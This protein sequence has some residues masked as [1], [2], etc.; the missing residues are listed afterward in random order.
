[1][2]IR[3]KAVFEAGRGEIVE[4][5]SRFIAHVQAVD[6]VE[7]A[8]EFIEAVKKKYWDAR[9]NCSAFSVGEMNP[10]TRCSDD[11]EPGGTAGK[12]ILEVIQGS[13]IRNIVI[14]VTRYF[15]GTLLGTGGLVRAYTEAAKAG[16]ENA[17]IIEKIPATRMKLF[18][19]YTDL[20]KIQYILAQNQVTVENTEYTDK[21]EIRAL[22][23]EKEKKALCRALT[24]G[25]G[26]RVHIEDGEDVYY[27]TAE[28]E[29]IIF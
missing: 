17:V 6:S 5:K 21:V 7:E 18:T 1:M 14:V 4:K 28:G 3:H 11:G 8:Q 9:H 13:G 29:V 15:G 2:M 10:L 25:T 19:E 12:P 27:G 24:E 23:P 22:F 20:G 16:I 26:G